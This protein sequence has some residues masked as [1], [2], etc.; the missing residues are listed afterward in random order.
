MSGRVS[1]YIHSG[2]F[3]DKVMHDYMDDFAFYKNVCKTRGGKVLE[4]CCGTGR[5]TIPLHKSGIDID[6]VDI[7]A[8][9]LERAKQ[10]AGEE[11]ASI[12]FYQQDIL[13]L[14]LP[15]QYNIILIPFNSMQCLYTNE[16]VEQLFSRVKAL[17]LPGGSFVFDV[18]NPSISLL[19]SRAQ[20]PYEVINIKEPDGTEIVI[21]ETCEYDSALQINHAKW[22]VTENGVESV[23]AL[24][25]RCFYPLELNLLLAHHGFLLESKF[26]D[27]DG[28]PFTS[29]SMKQVCICRERM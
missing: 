7:S 26:G 2:I 9:M 17:L 29:D 5:L 27:F 20:T 16:Q 1:D 12:R 13:K 25:T 4:L 8:S 6:G 21:T 24:D 18:Y 28:A 19:V 15:E 22:H 11:G 10:K 3:Y 14:K 23:H